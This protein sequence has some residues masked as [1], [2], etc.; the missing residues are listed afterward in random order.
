[1]ELWSRE[2]T[3]ILIDPQVSQAFA[4]SG[5]HANPRSMAATSSFIESERRLWK[6]MLMT[7]RGSG[8]TTR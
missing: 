6:K 4:T 5:L 3:K 8:N 2:V 1:M 7:N